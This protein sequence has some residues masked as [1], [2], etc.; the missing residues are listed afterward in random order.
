VV[1]E[2]NNH[3]HA[4]I[5]HLTMGQA[6]TNLYKSDNQLGWLTNVVSRP[7]MLEHFR[8]FLVHGSHM[9][10]SPRLLEECRTFIRYADGSCSAA[11]GAHD[12]SVIA[13]AIAQ[14]VRAE[15]R[16][17][18]PKSVEEAKYVMLQAA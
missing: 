14:A 5:A 16:T 15:L 1:V 12:D 6:Y 7:R 13:M 8:L 4:V 11:P 18:V 2:R 10:Q 17:G 9:F 3:G